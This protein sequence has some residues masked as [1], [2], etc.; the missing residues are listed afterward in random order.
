ME[1]L[2]PGQIFSKTG[3]FV[4]IKSALALVSFILS[5]VVLSIISVISGEGGF[6]IIGAAIWLAVSLVIAFAINYFIGYVFRAGHAAIVAEAIEKG[7][8]PNAQVK[9]AKAAV[10]KRFITCNAYASHRTAVR[11]S[12][13]QLQKSLNVF[14]IRFR[15]IPVL[16][17]FI[18]FIQL[19]VGLA[20]SFV[21]DC[22]LGYTIKRENE[23]LY[24][25][26]VNSVVAYYR[27]WPSLIDNGLTIA[28]GI[29]AVVVLVFFIVT[30]IFAAVFT[31]IYGNVL[32]GLMAAFAFSTFVVYV[33]K[34]AII[35]SY[36]MISIMESFLQEA[37]Y[38]DFTQDMYE[39]LYRTSSKFAALYNKSR[40]EE[41]EAAAVRTPTQ[42]MV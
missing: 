1:K 23:G 39:E 27:N 10:S 7:F 35:D 3:I 18:S 2:T 36:L 14:G 37:E 24:K 11:G 28:V 38:M 16:S 29:I 33:I 20:L 40:Q 13:Q 6:N 19:F 26:T 17:Q 22:C 34:N 9:I 21:A 4:L 30:S 31:A 42:P 41:D 25:S 32:A 12:V 15:G 8:V 5:L